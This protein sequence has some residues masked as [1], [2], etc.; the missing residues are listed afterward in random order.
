[1][2]NDRKSLS[3]HLFTPLFMRVM[4]VWISAGLAVEK[5][6]AIQADV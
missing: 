6:Q 2:F 3:L 5:L 4:D 1:M